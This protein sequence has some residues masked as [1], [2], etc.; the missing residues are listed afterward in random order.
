MALRRVRGT[1]AGFQIMNPKN[2]RLGRA[3]FMI[4]VLATGRRY[5]RG[6]LKIDNRRRTTY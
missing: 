3:F 4:A 2:A 1:Q 5:T 6:Q